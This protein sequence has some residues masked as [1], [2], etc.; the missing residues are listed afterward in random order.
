MIAHERTRDDAAHLQIAGK[1][2]SGDLA[3]PV[4]LLQRN[5]GL[6]RRNL[7]HTVRRGIHNQIPCPHV[8]IPVFLYYLRT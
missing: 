7:K 4:E 8:L 5:D 3:I 1:H 6:V 2:L